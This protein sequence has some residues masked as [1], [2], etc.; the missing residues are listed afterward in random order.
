MVEPSTTHSTVWARL[1]SVEDEYLRLMAERDT[2]ILERDQARLALIPLLEQV[3]KLRETVLA[4]LPKQ[5]KR[6]PSARR[7]AYEV[8]DADVDGWV[9]Q[10]E[11]GLSVTAIAQQSQTTPE[12]VRGHLLRRGVNVRRRAFGNKSADKRAPVGRCKECDLALDS[13]ALLRDDV[14]PVKDGVCGLC[15][16]IFTDLAEERAKAKE[17]NGNGR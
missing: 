10:Y 8:T 1:A 12:T 16:I 5:D 3:E 7:G 17:A 11:K 4:Q 13:P 9:R 2:A 15:Q 14:P 6:L